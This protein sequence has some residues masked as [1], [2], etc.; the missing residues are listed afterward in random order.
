MRM[1]IVS[2]RT[3]PKIDLD[4]RF[5]TFLKIGLDV[6]WGTFPIIVLDVFI[7]GG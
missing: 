5:L 2:L 1:T 4:V 3:F 7:W 6:S